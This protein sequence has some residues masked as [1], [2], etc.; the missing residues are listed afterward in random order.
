[1]ALKRPSSTLYDRLLCF[2]IEILGFVME[3]SDPL[4]RDTEQI[5][6]TTVNSIP[7]QAMSKAARSRMVRWRASSVVI[8]VSMVRPMMSR[9]SFAVNDRA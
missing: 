9:L 3:K 1:V 4:N 5:P 7:K 8:Q 6:I 2:V